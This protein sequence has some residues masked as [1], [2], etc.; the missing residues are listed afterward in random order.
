M[1]TPHGFSL[2]ELM[3]VLMIIAVLAALAIPNYQL[4]VRKA[5]FSEVIMHLAPYRTAVEVCAQLLG[6]FG[7]AKSNCGTPDKNGIPADF[8]AASATK[9]YISSLKTSFQSPE[10][11]LTAITQG[12]GKNYNYVLKGRATEGEP[13]SWSVDPSSTCLAEGLC[14]E[15]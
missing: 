15:E 6:G 2:L 4:Y 14:H 9:G 3:I 1:H 7:D 5:K 8:T 11:I 13:L 10:V 12:L